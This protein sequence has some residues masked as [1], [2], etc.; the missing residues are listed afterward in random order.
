MACIVMTRIVSFHS[1]SLLDV[2]TP[3]SAAQ[4][5]PSD[6]P[7]TAQPVAVVLAQFQDNVLDDITGAFRT[8]IDSGQVWALIVG[9]ILGYVVRGITTYR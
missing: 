7:T 2:D 5:A 6:T 3:L 9:I 8:F 1:S 4:F